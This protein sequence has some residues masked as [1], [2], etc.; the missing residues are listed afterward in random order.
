MDVKRI[1][2]VGAAALKEAFKAAKPTTVQPR[3]SGRQQIV[4]AP[5]PVSVPLIWTRRKVAIAQVGYHGCTLSAREVFA[6]GLRPMDEDPDCLLLAEGPE[7]RLLEV[8]IDHAYGEDGGFENACR[9]GR[10]FCNS[11]PFVPTSRV[12]EATLEFTE[13]YYHPKHSSEPAVRVVYEI[14]MA[15]VVRAR[16]HVYC[17]NS[18]VPAPY[19]WE[20]EVVVLGA[21]EPEFIVRA[22]MMEK[23]D[24]DWRV[25]SEIANPNRAREPDRM[26]LA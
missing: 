17:L 24:L 11:T 6:N 3:V 23:D 12:F 25:Q 1:A 8:L 19:T 16:R 26:L 18:E 4:G 7:Q 13:R 20:T 15:A 21:I 22:F 10:A 2:R 14:D 5:D 9:Q